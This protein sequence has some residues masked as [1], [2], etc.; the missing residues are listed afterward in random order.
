MDLKQRRV[1][2]IFIVRI[3]GLKGFQEAVEANFPK[4]KVQL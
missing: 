3:D 4:T 1:K 2:L